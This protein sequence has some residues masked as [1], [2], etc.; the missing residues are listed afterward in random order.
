LGEVWRVN[1]VWKLREI[2]GKSRGSCREWRKMSELA[3]E[4]CFEVFWELEATQEGFER[5]RELEDSARLHG[6]QEASRPTIPSPKPPTNVK[7]SPQLQQTP[8]PSK[9][10]PNRSLSASNSSQ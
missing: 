5:L 3:V 1:W 4:N 8:N 10:L 6:F 9:K 7:K 2:D